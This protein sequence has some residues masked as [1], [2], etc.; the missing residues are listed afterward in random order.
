MALVVCMATLIS[1]SIVAPAQAA[2][3]GTAENTQSDAT[4]FQESVFSDKC[5]G[6]SEDVAGNLMVFDIEQGT[7]AYAAW[8]YD[9][10][11]STGESVAVPQTAPTAQIAEPATLELMEGYANTTMELTETHTCTAT[12][13]EAKETQV[14]ETAGTISGTVRPSPNGNGVAYANVVLVCMETGLRRST[15]TDK[16]GSYM[17]TDVKARTYRLVFT[18]D[19]RNARMSGAL[20]ISGGKYIVDEDEFTEGGS[21]RALLVRLDGLGDNQNPPETNIQFHPALSMILRPP[22]I[23]ATDQ[24]WHLFVVGSTLMS[25]GGITGSSPGF[26]DVSS[27]VGDADYI[28]N[29][30]IVTMHFI[31]SAK[32]PE[33]TSKGSLAL[34][35]GSTGTN[36]L[37]ATGTEPVSFSLGGAPEGVGISGDQL[38][39]AATVSAGTHKFSIKANNAGGTYEQDFDLTIISAAPT[40]T[41]GDSLTLQHGAGGTHALEATGTVPVDFWMFGAPAGVGIIGSHL[42]ISASVLPGV[43]VF[44][45]IA[46]N[47]AGFDAQVFR[48]SITA[49]APAIISPDNLTLTQGTPA[50]HTI[51]ATGTA[52]I[53]MSLIGAPTGVVIIGN[54]LIISANVSPGAHVFVII[55]ENV[56]GVGVQVFTLTI[57]SGAPVIVSAD[58]LLVA[59]GTAAAHAIEVAGAAPIGIQLYMEPE[60]VS[61]IGNQILV[62]AT[63]QPGEYTFFIAAG[64]T[65]DIDVQTFTLTIA[66]V[67]PIIISADSLAVAH[68]TTGA[69]TLAASGTPAIEFFLQNAPAGVGISGNQLTIPA[70]L[71]LGLH[72]FT[73]VAI[74]AV[75]IDRQEFSLSIV[76]APPVIT[77]ANSRTAIS[78]FVDFHALSATGTAPVD[79]SLANAPPGVSVSGNLLRID[80]SMISGVYTFVIF[81]ENAAGIYVQT[82][83]LTITEAPRDVPITSLRIGDSAGTPVTGVAFISRNTSTQFTVILNDGASPAGV[84]WTLTGSAMAR[85]DQNGL[86]TVMNL[87]SGLL[88]LT[89]RSPCGQHA[90]SI[91]IRVGP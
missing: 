48:L 31:C 71:P 50:A 35:E 11:V 15:M 1:M 49:A 76:P 85:V 44:V 75:G 33:I 22:E 20:E 13:T 91:A 27:V 65:I 87:S 90:H 82:F 14:L 67:A 72:E 37:F 68:G 52:P 29:V 84:T 53:S 43:H 38:T 86:V 70:T 47:T 46:E 55:A 30:A 83:T 8:T 39:I 77:S 74:N 61:L 41:S 88:T 60:G 2:D 26:E 66:A 18:M 80:S 28:D 6:I 69:L 81:A 24:F 17:F 40:I 32:A 63:M 54:H 34:P 3:L 51:E 21:H 89:A 16:Q 36:T 12:T 5:P 56:G 64:N 78:G 59:A 7:N 42:T 19:G 79:F 25:T 9:G 45:I 62:S 4:P 23:N 73:I 57:A 10:A 58:N